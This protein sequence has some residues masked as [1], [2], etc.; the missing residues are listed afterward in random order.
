LI[1]AQAQPATPAPKDEELARLYTEDQKDREPPAGKSIDWSVVG[2]RD[3]ARLARVKELYAAGRFKTGA[4]YYHA[5][6]VLQHAEIP[7]DYVLLALLSEA[8]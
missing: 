4:D 8:R 3:A 1:P 5:A 6:M 7:E 2:P